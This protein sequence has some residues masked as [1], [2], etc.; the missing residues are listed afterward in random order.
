MICFY[1]GNTLF[2]IWMLFVYGGLGEGCRGMRFRDAPGLHQPVIGDTADDPPQHSFL[3]H[4]QQCD[5]LLCSV[6]EL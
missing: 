1:Q 2:S 6:K 4:W 5:L 3:L